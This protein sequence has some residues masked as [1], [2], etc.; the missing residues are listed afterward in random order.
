METEIKKCQRNNK[1]YLSKLY[2]KKSYNADEDDHQNLT[3]D[4]I[5]AL[6]KHLEWQLKNIDRNKIYRSGF[7]PHETLCICRWLFRK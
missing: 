4:N 2:P 5:R 6:N 1:L 7:G 3:E